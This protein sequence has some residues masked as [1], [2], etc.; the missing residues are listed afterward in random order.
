MQI[1]MTGITREKVKAVRNS[2]PVERADL[3]LLRSVI[4]I[5]LAL[6]GHSIIMVCFTLAARPSEPLE[7]ASKFDSN[8]S[9]VRRKKP[10]AR[11]SVMATIK[12]NSV[13]HLPK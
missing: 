9:V 3:Q 10:L 6:N 13:F 4:W 8:I 7:C 5:P 12:W 2:C 11:D 1:S